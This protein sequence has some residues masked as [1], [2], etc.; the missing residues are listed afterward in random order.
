MEL[1]NNIYK[2]KRLD[3]NK[4]IYGS[5][6]IIPIS[7]DYRDF[8]GDFNCFIVER[9]NE[10]ALQ[11]IKTQ[12]H[13]A[14]FISVQVKPETVGKFTGYK[15]LKGK[16]LYIGDK[17]KCHSEWCYII[18]QGQYKEDCITHIEKNDGLYLQKLENQQINNFVEF[19]ENGL[20]KV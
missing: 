1:K 12:T 20:K 16:D 4:L 5:L 9:K 17:V 14:T 18:K 3:N 13:E 6:I 11:S 7:K 2:G 19:L 8:L 15:D 10:K